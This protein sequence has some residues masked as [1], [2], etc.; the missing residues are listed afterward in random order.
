MQ[1]LQVVLLPERVHGISEHRD[2]RRHLGQGPAVR[3][4][5]PERAVGQAL[6]LIALFV[7]RA[8]V[9]MAE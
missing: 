1:A 4:S 3:P 2:G 5:E 9:A 8:V 6:D 7:N